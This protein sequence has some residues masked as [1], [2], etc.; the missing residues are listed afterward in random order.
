MDGI[1]N[2]H[3]LTYF[4]TGFFIIV[5]RLCDLAAVVAAGLQ[6]RKG[7][8]GC[9]EGFR[10]V[11]ITLFAPYAATRCRRSFARSP[12]ELPRGPATLAARGGAG[13]RR[14][15]RNSIQIRPNRIS[16]C[17]R[18]RTAN[19]RA[20][21]RN[22]PSLDCGQIACLGNGDR[23]GH[24]DPSFIFPSA[25]IFPTRDAHG[26]GPFRILHSGGA[27]RDDVN[28]WLNEAPLSGTPAANSE[29]CLARPAGFE[30][31][32]PSLEGSCSIRLSYGRPLP[33]YL[34]LSRSGTAADGAAVG[35]P[36]PSSARA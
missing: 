30:P 22:H 11:A 27:T 14:A 17:R 35:G 31:A 12:A 16:R 34:G 10:L 2:E 23:Q 19:G 3:D 6:R 36:R 29:N 18:P 20:S 28:G 1:D 13:A 5:G 4:L 25:R 8:C 21:Q 26:F 24:S 9:D 33:S 7:Q 15:G 32:T